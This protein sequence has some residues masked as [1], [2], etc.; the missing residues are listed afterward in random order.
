MALSTGNRGAGGFRELN[1][2]LAPKTAPTKFAT[3]VAGVL[4]PEDGVI[5]F[6]NAGHVPPLVISKSGIQRLGVTDLVVG[7]FPQ[8]QYR[9]QSIRLESGDSL[10]LF[11][12]GVAEERRGEEEFGE[13]RL[14]ELLLSHRRRTAPELEQHILEHLRNFTAGEYSD[15]VTMIVVAAD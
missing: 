2:T 6:T 14:I 7:L 13:E 12:D 15:D 9:N 4:N 3:L 8:A 5:D 1:V 10:V 11:T